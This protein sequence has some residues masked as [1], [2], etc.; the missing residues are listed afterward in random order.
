MRLRFLIIL[1]LLLAGT[2]ASGNTLALTDGSAA[3]G[4]LAT[5]ALNL[6]NEDFVGGIQLDVL[7]NTSVGVFSGVV[8]TGRGVGMVAEA[9]VVESG[10]LRVVMYFSDSGSI[11]ANTGAVAELEFIMQ[12]GADDF[13]A[14]T[15]DDIVLSDPGGDALMASGNPGSLTV[16]PATLA[17][18]LKISVLKNP[19][20][21]HIVMI[22][23]AI[24]GGSGDAPV[25]SASG[26]AITMTSLGNGIFQGT[27]LAVTGQ[28]TLSISATDTNSHGTGNAQI[29]LAL[30]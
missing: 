6:T 21:T 30:P 8:A 4:S 22:M 11:G 14:L 7:F 26:S 28:S 29:V 18:S 9:R 24:T 5:V 16:L 25:V 3:T 17:P 15:I 13:C 10:R 2:S 1:T 23:V 12:G 20:N 27:Y 19:G